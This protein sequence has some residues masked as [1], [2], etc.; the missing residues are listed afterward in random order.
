MP[1]VSIHVEA[2]KLRILILDNEFPPLGGG[3]GVINYHLMKEFDACGV[4]CD[5][6][7]SSRSRRE[8]EE[9]T[10][11]RQSRIFKVPV[12]NKNIHHA[13]NSE[14]IRY[15]MRGLQ[16]AYRL[17]KT[18]PY[19]VCLAFA[20][21]PAGAV[22]F[23]L[24]H[25]T[26]LPY[27]LSLQGPDVPW[28]EQRYNWLYPILLPLIKGV[29]RHAALVTAQSQDNKRLALQTMPDLPISIV[30]NGVEMTVFK[31]VDQPGGVRPLT[32]LCVGRLIERKG[33]HHLLHAVSLLQQR[34]YVDQVKVVFVGTGDFE[35]QLRQLCSD[36]HLQE[37]VAFAGF[38][39]RDEVPAFYQAAD[40]FVLPSFNEGMSVALL[41]ALSAGLPV[42]V[43]DTGGTAE[44]VCD[45]GLIVPWANPPL[46][47]E[48]I[49]AFL[50]QPELCQ[51][52]GEK[53]R[54]VAQKF[55]WQM[56]AN[57]YLSLF[58]QISRDE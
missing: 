27:I 49:E 4:C 32:L 11:G 9:E 57:T 52:M 23:A 38:Q 3:T 28:Y 53:S 40:V 51:R 12:D 10:F 26:G 5:L 7:T 33:Q 17:Q 55:T 41:E 44:L 34:G 43:T 1:Q 36:L 50:H 16:R 6:V 35:H 18:N 37:N 39:E 46:L 21:V 47:A 30:P 8:Y 13:S 56:A 31:P 19:D 24:R 20:G 45:N 42:I 58:Q 2:D 25:L 15:A 48:A 14:L 29:W 22:A 54:E